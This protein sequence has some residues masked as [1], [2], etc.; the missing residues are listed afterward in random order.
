MTFYCMIIENRPYIRHINHMSGLRLTILF[1]ASAL[2]HQFAFAHSGNTNSD[3]CHNQ[4]SNNTYHCHNSGDDDYGHIHAQVQI[5]EKERSHIDNHDFKCVQAPN[6][7]VPSI[8]NYATGQPTTSF[9][10]Q[11]WKDTHIVLREDNDVTYGRYTFGLKAK[12]KSTGFL[13]LSTIK[14]ERGIFE[15]YN[16]EKFQ[17]LP[18]YDNQEYAMRWNDF[19][20][21]PSFLIAKDH[22]EQSITQTRGRGGWALF[23]C[24]RR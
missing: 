14:G 16:T 11:F 6:G 9:L 8:T 24:V 4:Y 21:G 15:F 13:G 23:N 17:R 12:Q 18:S 5:Y 22:S 1:V 3:G 2:V 19:S 7:K 10:M 20:K